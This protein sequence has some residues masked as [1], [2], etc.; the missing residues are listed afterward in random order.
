MTWRMPLSSP[1]QRGGVVQTHDAPAAAI[2]RDMAAMALACA[3][4]NGTSTSLAPSVTMT[5]DGRR[6]SQPSRYPSPAHWVVYAAV[7]A[8]ETYLAPAARKWGRKFCWNDAST[9]ESPM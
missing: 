3:M 6:A 8:L 2:F 5:S 9:K 4:G 7:R 1:F